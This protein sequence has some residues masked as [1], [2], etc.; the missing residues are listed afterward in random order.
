MKAPPDS[1]QVGG[2]SS[3]M[4]PHL[5][6]QM[7]QP[8]NLSIDGGGDAKSTPIDSRENSIS[9]AGVDG[10]RGGLEEMVSD[11]VDV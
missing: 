3:G 10:R 9:A 11:T 8:P 1:T 2:Q 7:G 5:G 6:S 4:H